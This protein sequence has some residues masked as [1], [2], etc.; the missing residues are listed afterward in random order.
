M[1]CIHLRKSDAVVKGEKYTYQLAR[2]LDTNVRNFRIEKCFITWEPSALTAVSSAQISALGTAYFIDFD[3]LSSI[4]PGGIANGD[5]IDSCSDQN[6]GGFV[7]TANAG[8]EWTL[9]NSTHYIKSQANWQKMTDTSTV[10]ETNKCILGFLFY[11]TGTNGFIVM[12]TSAFGEV[13]WYGNVLQIR[14]GAGGTF[15][16]TTIPIGSNPVAVTISKSSTTFDFWVKDLV[17]GTV[18][19]DSITATTSTSTSYECGIA[20]AQTGFLDHHVGSFFCIT[21]NN[22][23]SLTLAQQYLETK[24]TGLGQP[25][26]IDPPP[27]LMLH[28]DWLTSITKEDHLLKNTRSTINSLVPYHKKC[29]DVDCW[30]LDQPDPRKTADQNQLMGEVDIFFSLPNDTR[31]LPLDFHVEISFEGL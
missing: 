21:N 8:L 22:S 20:T 24:H 18:S 17:T 6:Q 12:K 16:P 2:N 11:K 15:V 31:L 4:L 26:A 3:D 14:E 23:N 13:W 25:A 27:F 30:R 7:I 10:S 1:R 28:S 19:T 5:D 9:V 29:G